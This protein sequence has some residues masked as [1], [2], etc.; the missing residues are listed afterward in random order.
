M[1]STFLA[2]AARRHIGSR[3]KAFMVVSEVMPVNEI[4]SARE[5]A[6]KYGLDLLEVPLSV[7]HLEAFSKHPPDRCYLCKKHVFSTLLSLKPADWTLADGSNLD[8]RSD[9]R[10]GRRALSEL[11]VASPLEIAGFDKRM[12]REALIA[13]GAAELIRPPG[14]CLATRIPFETPVTLEKLLQIQSGE[15][16]LREAGFPDSRLRHHGSLARIEVP[17]ADVERAMAALPALID[18][19]KALGFIDVVIDTNGYRRGSMNQ[20]I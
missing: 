11:G 20:V 9:H 7:L 16:L 19:I 2:L 17:V 10:P 13:W 5:T 15:S 1:D 3:S 8:D 12:I 18:R 4:E 6:V 14:P